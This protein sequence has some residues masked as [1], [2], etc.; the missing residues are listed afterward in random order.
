MQVRIFENSKDDF[1]A[2]P[3]GKLGF[4]LASCHAF[5]EVSSLVPLTIFGNKDPNRNEA[6]L[7]FLMVR[8]L[9]ILRLLL[10]KLYE[11]NNICVQHKKTLKRKVLQDAYFDEN[12]GGVE[13]IFARFDWLPRVRN[14]LTFHYDRDALLEGFRRMEAD[15][16]LVFA[17][18]KIQGLTVFGFA[19][20]AASQGLISDLGNG[21]LQ[22]GL[23]AAHDAALDLYRAMFNFMPYYVMAILREYKITS[24]YTDMAISAD[25]LRD[26]AELTIPLAPD[27][28]PPR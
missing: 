27:R 20:E 21:D 8:Q 15:T 17:A 13:E 28:P 26:P 11:W 2:L 3:K 19:E 6:E 23:R 10:S 14:K 1:A 16:R 7:A 18:G 5:N 12:Y 4:L 24:S 9:T 25:L 22:A